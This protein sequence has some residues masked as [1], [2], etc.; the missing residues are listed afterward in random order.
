VTRTPRQAWEALNDRQRVYLRVLYRAD[1]DAEKEHRSGGARGDFDQRPAAEWRRISFNAWPSPIPDQ[2]AAAGVYD[3]GA[4]ATLAALRDRGLI[5]TENVPTR[6]GAD[7]VDVWVTRAGRAAARH[8]T[9]DTPARRSRP[10]WATSEW[11]WRELVKVGRSEP[12][13]LRA[14]ELYGS[15]DLYLGAG[16]AGRPGNRPYL[17]KETV[18]RRYEVRTWDG[19]PSGW[20]SKPVDM[21]H[22]TDEGRAHYIERAAEY[23][24]LFPGIDAPDL[25]DTPETNGV[26]GP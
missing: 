18:W 22:L 20:T 21:Y 25:D 10:R 9:G 19:E 14:S 26:D 16:F 1:Q 2:L 23:R 17:R 7:L 24:E 11:L 6:A 12:E 3:R 13:G 15:A 8:G 4:G 5:E